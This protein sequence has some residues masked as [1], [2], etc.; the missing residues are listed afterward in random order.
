MSMCNCRGKA[1]CPQVR[2]KCQSIQKKKIEK[3]FQHVRR[4]VFDNQKP[5]DH[6]LLTDEGRDRSSGQKV[7]LYNKKTQLMSLD[8]D[9]DSARSTKNETVIVN[10]SVRGTQMDFFKDKSINSSHR[11]SKERQN[12]KRNTTAIDGP[13]IVINENEM[14]NQSNGVNTRATLNQTRIFSGELSFKEAI[15]PMIEQNQVLAFAQKQ[16]KSK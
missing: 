5:R 1:S 12:G 6:L 8:G 9:R 15:L 4:S 7:P 11:H 10:N 3:K 16:Q 13:M 2:C 14:E